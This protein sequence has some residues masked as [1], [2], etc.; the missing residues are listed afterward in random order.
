VLHQKVVLL[1]IVNEDKP[2]VSSDDRITLNPLG[3]EIYQVIARFGFM[4]TPDVPA[5][6]SACGPLGLL[7]DRD[8][9]TYYLG[10][11]A[12]IVSARPGMAQWRKRF[13]ALISRNARNA[14]AYFGIPPDRVVELGMQIEI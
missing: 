12:M 3:Q 1:S 11:E 8:R 2:Y 4:E 5:L 14:T 6:V 7:V 9:T 13:F 10:R